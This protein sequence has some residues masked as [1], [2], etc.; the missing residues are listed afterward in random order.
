MFTLWTVIGCFHTIYQLMNLPSITHSR[1][2][3]LAMKRML[4]CGISITHTNA[5]KVTQQ[6]LEAVGVVTCSHLYKHRVVLSQLFSQK[7]YAYFL[8]VSLGVQ[9]ER[10]R[11]AFSTAQSG[12][13]SI[14]TERTFREISKP[15]LL[16]AKCRELC[17]ALASELAAKGISGRTVTLKIK[18]IDFEIKSRAASHVRPISSEEDLAATT[19]ALLEKELEQGPLR[20]RL[21]GV[22]LSAFGNRDLGKAQK[23]IT[24]FYAKGGG[25]GGSTTIN[26]TGA[27][28]S[29]STAHG[30]RRSA[31]SPH[32]A[33]ASVNDR[34]D[35]AVGRGRAR[36][37]V[38]GSAAAAAE[39]GAA[40]GGGGGGGG[41]GGVSFTVEC[42]ICQ[43]SVP[44]S[45]V[46]AHVDTCL[47]QQATVGSAS[48]STTAEAFSTTSNDVQFVTGV[49]ADV[50]G[51]DG[52]DSDVV[53]L[54]GVEQP[55][56]V[57]AWREWS[58]I[59][60][61][62]TTGPHD[63]TYW[64]NTITRNVQWRH[65]KDG[66]AEL[67]PS[68]AAATTT[69]SRS[70]PM[71]AAGPAAA[72]TSTVA[73]PLRHAA[74]AV[75]NNGSSSSFAEAAA[76]A[77]SP[78]AAASVQC[79]ICQRTVLAAE[80]NAHVDAC[81]NKSEIRNVVKKDRDDERAAV[82]A[83]A[84]A[85]GG[86]DGGGGSAVSSKRRSPR[87]SKRARTSTAGSGGSNCGGGGGSSSASCDIAGPL[88]G[89]FKRNFGKHK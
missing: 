56:E 71:P 77:T 63:A 86:G 85:A 37:G 39:G 75:G 61:P 68:A 49:R 6:V 72:R 28:T 53:I 42:P 29:S 3:T 52:D 30:T 62:N 89:F 14:S 78:T 27:S 81:L 58:C 45:S 88:D 66:F 35:G 23:S 47:A 17:A 70:P 5:G 74:D 19:I 46:N 31:V 64:F 79:P 22:R 80:V 73:S 25:V 26:N 15:E 43:T 7:S 18:T 20:L 33:K 65:P 11:A 32:S 51:D 36:G 16:K 9:E 2:Y 12:R 67:E 13:K 8:H 83:A 69:T 1:S 24:S 34:V 76:A 44:E 59:S 38:G 60:N 55:D 50:K 4:S 10:Q 57:D 21:M 82:A 41:G 40:E 87:P 48:I 54:D 84:A